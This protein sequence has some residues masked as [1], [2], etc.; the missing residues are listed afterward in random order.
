M[1]Q[2]IFAKEQ[3]N[4]LGKIGKKPIENLWGEI[5]R[6]LADQ[7][8]KTLEDLFRAINRILERLPNEYIKKL[9]KKKNRKQKK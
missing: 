6:Q 8:H 4:R 9:I 1:D 3:Y 5:K 2:L 7:N